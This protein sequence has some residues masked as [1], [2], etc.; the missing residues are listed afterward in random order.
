LESGRV[1]ILDK[2]ADLWAAKKSKTE[3]FGYI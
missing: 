3:P 1:L 2:D